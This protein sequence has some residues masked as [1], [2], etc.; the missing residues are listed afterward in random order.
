VQTLP[1]LSLVIDVIVLLQAKAKSPEQTKKQQE[2][3]DRAMEENHE[4]NRQ[5]EQEPEERDGS[6]AGIEAGVAALI[7]IKRQRE[8]EERRWKKE[9][10]RKEEEERQKEETDFCRVWRE[11]IELLEKAKGNDTQSAFGLRRPWMQEIKETFF[12]FSKM[13]EDAKSLAGV[14][15]AQQQVLSSDF[16]ASHDNRLAP[17]G[18]GGGALEGDAACEV[19]VERNMEQ[20]EEEEDSLPGDMS[21]EQWLRTNSDNESDNWTIWYTEEVRKWYKHAVSSLKSQ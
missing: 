13:E 19:D 15:A 1:R 8:E 7:Q 9:E 4:K 14:L 2:D 12:D 10:E 21:E 16:A 18:G 5:G 17:D 3:A 11:P 20:E 6:K